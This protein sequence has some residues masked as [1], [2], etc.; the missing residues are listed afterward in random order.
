MTGVVAAQLQLA[1]ACPA[2]QTA[3]LESEAEAEM[4]YGDFSQRTRLALAV[5]PSIACHRLCV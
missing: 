3:M 4:G 1:L 5:K 2:S